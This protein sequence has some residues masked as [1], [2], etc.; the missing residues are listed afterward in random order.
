MSIH[1]K[2]TKSIETIRLI[3]RRFEVRDAED[4]FN[5]WAGD[6]EVCKYLSWGPHRDVDVSRRRIMNWVSNYEYVDS[7]VW[8]IELKGR[9]KVVGSIS[10][11]ISNETTGSCEVGYCIGKLYWS[12][13]IMTEA[14][15]AIMHFL[16]YDVGYQR[17]QARHDV[18]NTASGRVMQKAGMQF[19]KIDLRVGVRRDG[20]YYDCAVYSKSIS[21]D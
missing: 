5:N 9:K 20:S 8:A 16:F 11:E 6:L 3:L 14:Y 12:R 1:H 18:L 19:A 10:V 17:I 13:G 21:D 15:R 7:Y 4:M 2:G